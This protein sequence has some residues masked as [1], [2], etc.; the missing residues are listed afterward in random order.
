MSA[1]EIE[2]WIEHFGVITSGLEEIA[3]TRESD[4]KTLGTGSYLIK[5]RLTRLIPN[6][7][8]MHGLKIKCSYQ[9]VKKQC[10]NCYEYHRNTNEKTKTCEKKTFEEYIRLFEENNP[11]I[12]RSMMNLTNDEVITLDGNSFDGED[13]SNNEDDSN[14]D[15]TYESMEDK[16]ENED[17]YF[18]YGYSYDFEPK[19]LRD[20]KNQYTNSTKSE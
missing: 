11:N 20:A 15:H 7:I 2:N 18:N 8:P 1:I 5:V 14:E 4:G 19:W 13:I 17:T 16:D 12:P 6:I 9:G 3:I 10:S